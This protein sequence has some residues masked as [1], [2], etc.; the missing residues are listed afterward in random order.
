MGKRSEV[1]VSER[2]AA[3]LSFLPREEPAAA[4]AQ[5]YGVAKASL[6]RW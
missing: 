5:Q 3:V 1:P 2:L 6:Y 4:I